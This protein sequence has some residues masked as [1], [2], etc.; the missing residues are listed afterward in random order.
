M[1]QVARLYSVDD[2]E[3]LV[4][5]ELAEETEVPF[6]LPQIP[7]DLIW[8]R[9]CVAA[10]RSRRLTPLDMTWPDILICR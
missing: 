2:M 6:C 10:L 8:D 3:Q 9:T 5:R 1:L 4:E 7:H